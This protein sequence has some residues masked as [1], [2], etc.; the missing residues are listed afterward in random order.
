MAE[1]EFATKPCMSDIVTGGTHFDTGLHWEPFIG[2]G[3]KGIL[4]AQQVMKAQGEIKSNE[5][6]PRTKAAAQRWR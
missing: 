4:G 6:T 3:T 2:D 5:N 1:R